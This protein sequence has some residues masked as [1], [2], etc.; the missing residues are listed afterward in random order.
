MGKRFVTLPRE[1]WEALLAP[2]TPM[3][4]EEYAGARVWL[5][6]RLD[7]YAQSTPDLPI[8]LAVPY[9]FQK[10]LGET[11]ATEHS[12]SRDVQSDVTRPK[13]AAIQSK[14]AAG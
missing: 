3:D 13:R 9:R 6:E 5:A 1:A 12:G 2:S 11:A 8:T 10:I 14:R 7:G 4:S